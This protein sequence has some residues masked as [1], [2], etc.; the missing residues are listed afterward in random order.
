MAKNRWCYKVGWGSRDE[1]PVDDIA[2]V[3]VVEA[4]RK[5]DNMERG[6]VVS[7]DATDEY[8]QRQ[9]RIGNAVVVPERAPE[10]EVVATP[11]HAPDDYLSYE[12]DGED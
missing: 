6:D 7:V 2:T 4:A 3:I 9:I 8:W 1:S 10:Q 11:T 12:V 5:F